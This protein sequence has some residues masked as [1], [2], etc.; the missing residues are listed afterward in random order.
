[1]TKKVDVKNFIMSIDNFISPKA[2]DFMIE[3][4]TDEKQKFFQ[5]SVISNKEQSTVEN[6]RQTMGWQNIVTIFNWIA[7]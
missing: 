5:R 3:G 1:M 6:A 4:L 2:C 7:I